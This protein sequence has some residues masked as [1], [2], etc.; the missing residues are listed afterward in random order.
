[1][2]EEG[3]GGARVK[4]LVVK[5]LG[6]EQ[7]CP[8]TTGLCEVSENGATERNLSCFSTRG[9]VQLCAEGIELVTRQDTRPVLSAPEIGE[10]LMEVF[11][12]KRGSFRFNRDQFRMVAAH[13]PTA[14]LIEEVED[15]LATRGFLLKEIWDEEYMDSS[16]FVM[17]AYRHLRLLF[18]DHPE[19]GEMRQ[20][21]EIQ[22]NDSSSSLSDEPPPGQVHFVTSHS[23]FVLL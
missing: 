9:E 20:L 12:R 15:Y 16:F 14:R 5:A 4:A 22:E 3:M 6:K 2:E 10:R 19:D 13:P 7:S 11:H 18:K 21:G 1:M 8:E 23:T 17:I